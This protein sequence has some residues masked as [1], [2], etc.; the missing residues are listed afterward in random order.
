MR[1]CSIVIGSSGGIGSCIV[2]LLRKK[3]VSHSDI[4]TVA[5]TSR[6][7]DIK[8][9]VSDLSISDFLHIDQQVYC[10]DI[11]FCHRYRGLDPIE[12]YKQHVL[13]PYR[14]VL[15]MING[16]L[17]I[18]SIV[19]LTSTCSSSP[20]LNQDFPYHAC[21]GAI[22]ASIKKMAIDLGKYGT[23]VNGVALNT[24]IK[25]KNKIFFDQNTSITDFYSVH[26]PLGRMGEA[27]DIASACVSLAES[28]FSYMTGQ[29]I[30]VDGGLSLL[31][32]ECFRGA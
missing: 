18:R 21:R 30:C 29:I 9:S 23:R 32:Q 24:V 8:K 20:V 13:Q 7:S 11:Y 27:D 16:G 19:Y 3:G 4:I 28:A 5:R 2:N 14:L 12:E 31:N 1:T 6:S 15:E 22:D 25:D 26:T 10:I 17:S